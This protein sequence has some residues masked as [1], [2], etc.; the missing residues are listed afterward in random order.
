M[1]GVKAT[2]TASALKA[3]AKK[4][5]ERESGARGLRAILE[6]S[7]LDIMYEIPSKTG[8]KEIVVGDDV[9]MKKERPLIVYEKEAEVAGA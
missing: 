9:I 6:E 1:D 8:V 3:V 5:L 4:A 2:F 7:M